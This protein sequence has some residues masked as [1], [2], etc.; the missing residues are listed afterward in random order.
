MGGAVPPLACLLLWKRCTAPAAISGMVAMASCMAA[1]ANSQSTL[2]DLL[3][4]ASCS[5]CL[6]RER[7]YTVTKSG[8]HASSS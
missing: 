7:Q 6:Q 1:S 4:C 2:L 8:W 3:V 5:P